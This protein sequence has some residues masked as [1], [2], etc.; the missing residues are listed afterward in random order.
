M[1]HL[2]RPV[3]CLSA[4]C[5][6]PAVVAAQGSGLSGLPDSRVKRRTTTTRVIVYFPPP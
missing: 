1:N 2:F 4:L 3:L 5:V 6:L